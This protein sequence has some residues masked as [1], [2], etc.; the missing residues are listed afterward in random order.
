MRIIFLNSLEKK[1]AGAVVSSAQIWMGEEESQW[2][3]GWNEVTADGEQEYIWYEGSSWSEMLHVY[4]HRIVIKLGEGF[5]PAIDGVWED[6]EPLRGKA[7]IAQKLIC[8]SES[9]TNEPLYVE[10]CNWRRK[11]AS[12]ERKA[13]YLIASNRLL[14]LISV[15]VPQQLEELLELPGV[16]QN[17]AAEFGDELLAMTKNY[18]RTHSFPLDW[19]EQAVDEDTLRS[20]LYKQ[21]EAKFRVEMEKY[22]VRRKLLEGIAE[23]LNVEQIRE[24]VKMERREVIELVEELEKDGYNTEQLVKGELQ[25]MPA[26]EQAAVLQAYK[27]LGD[28]FLKPVL[29]QVYGQE[30]ADGGDRE[31]LYER[32][33]LIR[34]RFRRAG[35]DVRDAG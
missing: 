5:K 26:E 14:R 11:K 9:N 13:P 31:M 18:S 33:R 20:W 1:E 15:F 8:Y 10:L 25:S 7:M 30:A 24:Q 12:T 27:E 3:M 22:G 21:K 17:K 35:H 19:V 16:G 34:I 2:R 4:R 23:G 32:L 28:G 6:K 29:Q